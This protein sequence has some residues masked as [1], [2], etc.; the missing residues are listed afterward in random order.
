MRLG[1]LSRSGCSFMIPR[2]PW[3]N[4]TVWAT[5][6]VRHRLAR[7]EAKGRGC[8]RGKLQYQC[9]V[10]RTYTLAVSVFLMGYMVHGHS[11]KL[12]SRSE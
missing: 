4:G 11:C 6:I 2:F 3:L 7:A 10:S 5:L 12:S 8:S 9:E 1:E